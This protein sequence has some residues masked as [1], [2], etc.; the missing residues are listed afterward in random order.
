MPT[1]AK[2]AE[3]IERMSDVMTKVRGDRP[4]SPMSTFRQTLLALAMDCGIDWIRR[5]PDVMST[6]TNGTQPWMHGELG[7]THNSDVT[8]AATQLLSYLNIQEGDSRRN[9]Y[10]EVTIRFVACILDD[11]LKFLTLMPR[12]IQTGP[13]DWA[14][15]AAPSNRSWIAVPVV[16]AS[17]PLWQKR[18][19]VVEP[20]D[21]DAEPERP[22]EHLPDPVQAAMS[23][24]IA[25]DIFPVLTSDYADRRSTWRLRK[26]QEF[27]GCGP[28][29][30]DN[31]SAMIL[32][33]KQKVYGV[34]D[35]NW[36][37]IKKIS[38]RAES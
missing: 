23:D 29:V 16:L 31:N 10:L 7:G 8:A 22:E 3:M 14:I 28:L 26:E 18:A 2:V 20:F 6:G 36:A 4:G 5:F 32:L 27:F 24:R 34:E 30:A 19:W 1:D 35:Y 21:P 37:E 12:R 17:Q 9:D 38:Q 33:K 11:R 15:T 25:E 13:D